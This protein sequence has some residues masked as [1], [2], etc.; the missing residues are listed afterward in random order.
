M[1]NFK[2]EGLGIFYSDE[3]FICIGNWFQDN[4]EGKA[5]IFF[6]NGGY[7]CANF[8]NNKMNGLG[9]LKFTN[10]SMIIGNW[11]NNDLHGNS[12]HYYPEIL[13]WIYCEY[14]EGKLIKYLEEE[15]NIGE[16]IFIS[17]F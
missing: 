15:R 10:S 4:L 3:G 17:F 14:K 6:L 12:F 11:K 8:S 2:R 5:I 9:Y 13:L 1:L 7:L 16:C